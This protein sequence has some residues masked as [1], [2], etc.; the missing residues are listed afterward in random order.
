MQNDGLYRAGKKKF[1]GAAVGPF[2]LMHFI[3]LRRM[4]HTNIIY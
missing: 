2:I 4:A 3:T 1:R